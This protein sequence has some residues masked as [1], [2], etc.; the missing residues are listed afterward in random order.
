MNAQ[1]GEMNNCFAKSGCHV[2]GRWCVKFTHRY[3]CTYRILG[4]D[5][6]D[7]GRVVTS[8]Y[9]CDPTKVSEWSVWNIDI[10]PTL[11]DLEQV[12]GYLQSKKEGSQSSNCDP[13]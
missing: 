12:S 8:H 4:H 9:V 11:K 3:V 7:R 13:H 10:C 5:M 6:L 1:T 2:I